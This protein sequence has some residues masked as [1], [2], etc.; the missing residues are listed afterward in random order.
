MCHDDFYTGKYSKT[1]I[2][3]PWHCHSMPQHCHHTPW[4][5]CFIA[6]CCHNMPLHC[7]CIWQCVF[8]SKTLSTLT[9]LL[10]IKMLSQCPGA[11]SCNI[12]I[13]VPNSAILSNSCHLTP[14][15]CH[16]TLQWHVRLPYLCALCAVA[17]L[18]L[19]EGHL[20]T[21]SSTQQ[22]CSVTFYN[23]QKH[24]GY[25]SHNFSVWLPLYKPF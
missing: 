17:V 5:C 15:L 22:L 4:H 6:E 25:L 9:S 13:F 2:L 21:Q 8:V 10:Q 16:F 7:H 12:A 11:L 23:S 24:V 1:C 3:P 14:G 20:I 19:A 18:S